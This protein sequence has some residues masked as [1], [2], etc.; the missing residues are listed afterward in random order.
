MD[1][2]IVLGLKG[3]RFTQARLRTIVA[4][5]PVTTGLNPIGTAVVFIPFFEAQSIF[6]HPP[7]SHLIAA[8][9]L[10][11]F[12]GGWAFLLYRRNRGVADYASRLE[13]QLGILQFAVSAAWGA[14]VWLFWDPVSPVNHLYVALVVVTVVWNVLFT[15]MSHTL[16][17]LA[18]IVPLLAAF[19]IRTL[20][21]SDSVS[22]VL[23]ELLPIWATYIGMMGLVGRVRVD[24]AFQTGF[25]KEDLTVALRESKDEAERK[26]FEAEA[27][28]AAKT[29]FLANMSHELRTPL[30][31][32]LGFSDIIARQ[33]L[34]PHQLTRYSDYA[35]DIN[36]AGAHLLSLINDLLDVAKIEAGRMEIDPQPIDA[37]DAFSEIKRLIAPRADARSQTIVYDIDEALPR[38][39]ADARA[40]KQIALNLL[41]NAV[42]FTPERGR[43]AVSMRRAAQ[44]GV[45]L[46]VEDNGPGIAPEKLET[47]FKPFNQIDNRFGRQAGGTGLG[48]A[49]VKGLTQLH[50]G[51][52]W[53]ESTLGRGTMVFVYFPLAIEGQ[54]ARALASG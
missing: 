20:T 51:R 28:N 45:L 26:R 13:W 16:I 14:T 31:A 50:G 36:E 44:G 42:K 1:M 34:G 11:I 24:A 52:C 8:L 3:A 12:A 18:G 10:Q 40:F 23:S 6:G 47:V 49:L 54:P 46:T 21:A 33:A 53:I 41:S 19:W 25:A 48:L 2:D 9:A 35:T 7:W 27:A 22:H 32:I 15:R 5:L 37:A 29:A 39:L 17:F 4:A 43:I 38:V 30:N